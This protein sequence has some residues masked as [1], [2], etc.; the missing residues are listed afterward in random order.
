MSLIAA[1]N[2]LLGSFR[3]GFKGWIVVGLAV[4]PVTARAADAKTDAKAAASKASKGPA[5]FPMFATGKWGFMDA[6][7]KVVI[8]PL[9]QHVHICRSGSY[10]V[11]TPDGAWNVLDDR[12][13]VL[14]KNPWFLDKD[15]SGLG[16]R[17]F[18]E[19]FA[20]VYV[21]GY[22]WV[23]IPSDGKTLIETQSDIAP[24]SEGLAK[25]SHKKHKNRSIFIDRNG[26]FA[27][28]GKTFDW[29][30]SFSEGM[31]L[32]ADNKKFGYINRNGEVVIQPQFD[33]GAWFSQGLAAVKV[34][35]KW[36]FIDKQ[37]TMKIGP[38]YDDPVPQQQTLTRIYY[39]HYWFEADL[40]APVQLDDRVGYINSDGK[41]VIEFRFTAGMQFSE[42]LAAVREASQWGFIDR[43]GNWV[44]EPRFKFAVPFRNGLAW[45]ETEKNLGYIDKNAKIIW[46]MKHPTKRE[47]NWPFFRDHRQSFD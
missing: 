27:F 17:D 45:V 3:H 24:F 20:S 2:A 41:T 16:I 29:A 6:K 37:G 22:G 19:G 31:A 18:T 38:K 36:G 39:P 23:L 25:V 28:G 7:G 40:L 10:T 26:D 14:L 33:R 15:Y 47:P 34:G 4:A 1:W 30:S 12:G 13:K 44:I 35:S 46:R 9:Y 8:E 11:V 5:L 32:I 42:G 21:T 43:E